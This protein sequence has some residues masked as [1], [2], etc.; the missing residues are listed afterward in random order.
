MADRGQE[1]E[2][3]DRVYDLRKTT[4]RNFYREKHL[5]VRIVQI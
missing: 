3:M 2:G 4:L 1:L 5:H